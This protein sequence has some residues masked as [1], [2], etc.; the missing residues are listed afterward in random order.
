M[1]VII[2]ASRKHLSVA[3]NAERNSILL[4]HVEL[5]LGLT[6][7][8]VTGFWEG[9]SEQSF[10]FHGVR[11]DDLHIMASLADHYRQDAFLVVADDGRSYLFSANPQNGVTVWSRS[12]IGDWQQVSAR[13]AKEFSGYTVTRDGKH[14]VACTHAERVRAERKS[15]SVMTA[16]AMEAVA[17]A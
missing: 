17:Y 2:T 14:Y 15:L 4:E 16:A 12:D 8:P 7:Q 11:A 13:V 1:K 6:G 10:I 5:R 3:E 9:E